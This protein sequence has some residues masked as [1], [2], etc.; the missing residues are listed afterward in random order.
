MKFQP[1][2]NDVMPKDKVLNG[3]VKKYSLHNFIFLALFVRESSS[4]S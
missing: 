2:M 4:S 1:K 3:K